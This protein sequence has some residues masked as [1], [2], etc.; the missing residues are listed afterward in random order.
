M[1]FLVIAAVLCAVFFCGCQAVNGIDFYEPT[2]ANAAY[3]IKAKDGKVG[4]GP[5]KHID[6]KKGMRD[7]SPTTNWQ[8][9]VSVFGL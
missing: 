5:I 3:C 1:T 9:S 6:S 2:E 8:L 4:Y 7:V